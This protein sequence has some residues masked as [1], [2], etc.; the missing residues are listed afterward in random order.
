MST[1]LER[2]EIDEV[3]MDR[4]LQLVGIVAG[5]HHPGDVGLDELDS[6]AGVRITCRVE[7]SFKVIG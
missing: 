2:A 3:E 1:P 6:R 4:L 5:K 7:Q